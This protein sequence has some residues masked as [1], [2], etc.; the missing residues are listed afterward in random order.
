MS[1]QPLTG[2]NFRSR[3]K[4]VV[5]EAQVDQTH[6]A[7][8]FHLLIIGRAL[9]YDV[10]AARN[11]MSRQYNGQSFSFLSLPSLPTLPVSPETSQMISLIDIIWLEKGTGRLICEFEGEQSTS[12]YSGLL[13][14]TDL[15]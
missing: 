5:D 6:S 1:S 14:L 13:R 7:M 4:A 2:K 3:H 15:A 12:I 10:V 9:G 8:Q 11:D